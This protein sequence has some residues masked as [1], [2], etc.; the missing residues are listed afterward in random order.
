MKKIILSSVLVLIF[1]A[2]LV[3]ADVTTSNDLTG[4]MAYQL[5]CID[6]DNGDEIFQ[7]GKAEDGK[8]AGGIDYCSNGKLV[9][10]YCNLETLDAEYQ[11]RSCPQDYLCE[12][13]ACKEQKSQRALTAS[14]VLVLVENQED[15]Y[16]DDTLELNSFYDGLAEIIYVKKIKVRNGDEIYLGG[17]KYEVKIGD[18]VQLINK[19]MGGEVVEKIVEKVVEKECEVIAPKE[20]FVKKRF[21][22]LRRLFGR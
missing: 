11:E 19:G 10:Y 4:N 21:S 7:R 12:N 3:M 16:G 13:G 14:E 9:E 22:F 20:T 8:G 6:S 18:D 5:K 2:S 1:L 17:N 15:V